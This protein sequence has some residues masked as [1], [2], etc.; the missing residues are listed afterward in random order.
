MPYEVSLVAAPADITVGINRGISPQGEKKKMDRND[1]LKAK[2]AAIDE[3]AE[4]AKSGENAERMNDLKG[5]IR[6][7][8]ARLE[9]LDLAEAS[10]K[11]IKTFTPEVKKADRSIIEFTGG[12][13]TNRTY[14][15]MFN[16]GRALE[17][18]D[19][20]I[21]AFR[22]SMVEGVPASGG[23]SVPEPLA[24]Q[25]LDDSIESEIIRPRATVWP[26]DSATRK[27][28]G[29]DCNNQATV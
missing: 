2:K 11:D 9:A 14:A 19:E 27:V 18:N 3:M 8:D 24:A 28:P 25:W 6:A 4:L 23:L 16:Q 10:K 26:M 22:A 15:G 1:I 13:A 7:F 20:A 17:V 12:P 21:R 29:W 5:E